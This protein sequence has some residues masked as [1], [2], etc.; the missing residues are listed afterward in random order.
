MLFLACLAI[1]SIQP[2]STCSGMISL[3][4]SWVVPHQLVIKKMSPQMYPQVNLKEEIPLF[5]GASCWQ[6]T[7]AMTP[8]HCFLFP[9]ILK[10][11]HS[12]CLACSHFFPGPFIMFSCVE[13][14]VEACLLF[15]SSTDVSGDINFLVHRACFPRYGS[16]SKPRGKPVI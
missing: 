15:M 5:L 4:V 3:R 11:I 1:F 7:L 16:L 9:T 12:I 10:Q 6:L 13:D 14:I 2:R 8:T